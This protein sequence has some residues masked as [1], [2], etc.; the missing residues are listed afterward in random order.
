MHIFDRKFIFPKEFGTS[1]QIIIFWIS[2]MFQISGTATV[3]FSF[4][5]AIPNGVMVTPVCIALA[6]LHIGLL[7]LATKGAKTSNNF[8]KSVKSCPRNWRKSFTTNYGSF[9]LSHKGA[10]ALRICSCIFAA[11][12]YLNR[13]KSSI[14][15]EKP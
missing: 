4:I 7:G 1:E 13:C 3:K 14:T 10:K 5:V 15:F 12:T 2:K 6:F 9:R 11:A 8:C